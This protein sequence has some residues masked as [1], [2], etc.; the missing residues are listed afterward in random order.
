MNTKTNRAEVTL[1]KETKDFPPE[2]LRTL[3][4]CTK[5]LSQ[6]GVFLSP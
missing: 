1:D 3:S 5:Q 4:A 6:E 2:R